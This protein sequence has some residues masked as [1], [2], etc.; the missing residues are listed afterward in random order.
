M[1]CAGP[2][3]HAL[4][5]QQARQDP[6]RDHLSSVLPPPPGDA[7]SLRFGV[8]ELSEVRRTVVAAAREA[9]CDGLAVADLVTAANELAA[10]SIMHG[11]GSGT[12]RVW[13]EGSTLLV[14]VEDRG[15][16]EEQWAGR[17]PPGLKQEGGRGLW[18]ANQLCDRVEICSGEGGTRVRLH[19]LAR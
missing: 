19:F 7:G 14:E 16:I 9:G 15:R 2:R 11:G 18:I 12:L 17:V 13:R 3:Q 4:Q 6:I 8:A 1:D 5:E 10:N